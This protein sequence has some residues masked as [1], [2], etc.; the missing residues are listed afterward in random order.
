MF[1]LPDPHI[2]S[3]LDAEA[4]EQSEN[5]PELHEEMDISQ[6]ILILAIFCEIIRLG[7]S[8]GSQRDV[9]YLG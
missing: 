2:L 8:R 6:V 4:K 7:L 9:V 5:L 1:S 3:C